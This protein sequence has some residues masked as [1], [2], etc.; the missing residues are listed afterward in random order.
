[1]VISTKSMDS[2]LA[3]LK[4]LERIWK[5]DDSVGHYSVAFSSEVSKLTFGGASLT[6]RSGRR[7]PSGLERVTIV[8]LWTKAAD[9]EACTGNQRFAIE[10][11]S[12]KS[13]LAL[14]R[15]TPHRCHAMVISSNMRQAHG[16]RECDDNG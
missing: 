7:R 2:G 14:I 13:S 12:A 5:D 11:P 6:A 16:R 1:M 3:V 9:S 15:D 10:I 8:A 4:P